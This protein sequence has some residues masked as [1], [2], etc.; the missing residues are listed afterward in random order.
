MAEQSKE[1]RTAPPQ[2]PP[3]DVWSRTEPKY[4]RRAVILL[5]INVLLFAGLACVAYW[6]RTGIVFAPAAEGYGARLGETFLPTLETKHTP[7][8]LSLGPISIEQVP[9]MIPVLALVLAALVSIPVLTAM[10][11]RFPCSLP[12]IAAV[13]FLAVMPWL[14]IVLLLSCL[15][16]SLRPLRSSSR[17]VSAL[18]SLLP[19]IVYFFMASRQTEPVVAAL[20]SPADQIK[21]MAPLVL[22]VIASAVVMGVVLVIARIVNYRPGA[23]SPL[24]AILFLTPAVL[25]EFEVGR[26]E[27]HYRLLEREFGPASEYF[28]RQEVRELFEASVEAR[29]ARN[30]DLPPGAAA[31][32]TE[33]RWL[34]ELDSET[35]DIFARHRRRAAEAA[36]EFIRYF[37]DSIYACNALY[38][39]ARALDMRVD[40][41]AFKRER[42]V[43]FYDDFPSEAS[44]RAW[45]LIEANFADSPVAAVALLRLAEL[46]ARRGHIDDALARLERLE[47]LGET[48]SMAARSSSNQKVAALM[49]RQPP[50]AS[51]GI[52]VPRRVIEG[53]KLRSLLVNNRDPLYGDAPF[54]A[55]TSID[56]R[57]LN[58]VDRYG[59]IPRDFPSCQL[60]DNV[61]LRLAVA[62]TNLQ[63]RAEALRDWVEQNDSGDAVPEA[64]YLLGLAYA[65]QKKTSEALAAV[66]RVVSEFGDTVWGEQA[67]LQ[68]RRLERTPLETTE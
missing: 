32:L 21:V 64:L 27:L 17:F 41:R 9:M 49:R 42:A 50:V 23:I 60:T 22:A 3:A 55:Y 61:N 13:G 63:D 5:T 6:L 34:L 45:E 53:R 20:A 54:R 48:E 16:P 2:T 46:D 28:L 19:I 10:L 51:L 58:S 56:P 1:T 38:L 62:K 33:T 67:E 68:L 37:P 25:F 30:T 40:L 39:E 59:L 35:S 65:E 14:A 11:Y 36:E 8:G 26:D 44:R 66:E 29:E 18:V 31:E 57:E 15:L 4:R 12:F 24:L 7:T 43:V 47:A 52:S